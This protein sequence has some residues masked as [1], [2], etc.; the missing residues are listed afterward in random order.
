[1]F[2]PPR[3][4]T[5]PLLRA[6]E[7]CIPVPIRQPEPPGF[8]PRPD[9]ISQVTEAP[10]THISTSTAR[11]DGATPDDLIA[12]C[13]EHVA[14]YDV[15]FQTTDTALSIQMPG[16]LVELQRDPAGFSARIDAPDDHSLHQI[17]ETLLYL[18]D[19]VCPEAAAGL[20]W[21]GTVAR[22]VAPPNFHLAR[23]RSVTRAAPRFLRVEL[24]CDSTARM[25]TG[26]MHFSLLLP[27]PGRAPVWPHNNS[28]GRTIWPEGDDL[29]HRAAYTFVDLDPEAGRFTFD[30][31]EHDGG[32]TTEWARSAAPGEIVGITGPGG[33]DFPEGT[34]IL[35]AGDETALPAIRRILANSEPDRRGTVLIE[36][37]DS[38]DRCPLPA[39]AGITVTWIERA[40]GDSLRDHLAA[41]PLPP[42]GESRFVWVAAEQALVRWA[43]SHFRQEQQIGRGECYFSAYWSAD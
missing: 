42:A 43:R 19:H 36:I 25:M 30:V 39:P 7:F 29:L 35:L 14:A 13:A 23:V 17:R 15:P 12:H 32:R 28:N 6:G 1:M 24:D 8:R 27:P 38:A 40:S 20:N 22:D 3:Q 21:T 33:G 11:Y 16:V 9:D 31:F 4:P 2:S 18:L 26:G 34:H 10:L 5:G 41:A 37:T